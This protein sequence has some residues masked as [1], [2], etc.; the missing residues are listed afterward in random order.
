LI[1][2]RNTIIAIFFAGLISALGF[3][4]LPKLFGDIGGVLGVVL[5]GTTIIISIRFE[6]IRDFLRLH[7]DAKK[8]V[9][10]F[11]TLVISSIISFQV[12][13]DALPDGNIILRIGISILVGVLIMVTSVRIMN[14]VISFLDIG[15][16]DTSS[17]SPFERNKNEWNK[18]NDEKSYSDKK[19]N[20]NEWNKNNDEKSYSDKEAHED[21]SNIQS[22]YTLEESYEIL[23]LKKG[24]T[25]Q[26]IKESYRRLSLQ[27]HPDKHPH[28]DRKVMAEKEM[29][30]IIAAHAKLSKSKKN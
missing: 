26:E 29:K 16:R 30:R 1:T 4:I 27:W 9:F 2:L 24:A 11:F 28:P 20:E 7:L 14:Y 6:K 12:F 15:Y 22:E 23:G 18:N 13:S 3:Y 19:K 21:N 10:G 8:I 17:K 5:I 25:T